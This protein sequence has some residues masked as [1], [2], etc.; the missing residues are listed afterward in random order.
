MRKEDITRY[1]KMSLHWI[2]TV[3]L[4]TFAWTG[5]LPQETNRVVFS[6]GKFQNLTVPHNTTVEALVSRVPPDVTHITVQFHTRNRNATL[7]YSQVPSP[8]SAHTAV[9]AGLLSSL[10][11]LQ[12]SVTWFLLSPDGDPISGIGVILPYTTRDPVPGGCSWNHDLMIDPNVHLQY[13]LFETSIHF[14]PGNIGYARGATPPL[15]DAAEGRLEY[16]IHRYFLPAGDLSEETLLYHIQRAASLQNAQD[17]GNGVVTLSVANGTLVMLSVANGMSAVLSVANETW[18][19]FRS[20]PGRGVIYSVVVRDVMLNTTASYVPAHTYACSFTPLLDGCLTLGKISTKLFFTLCGAGGLFV[21]FF[22]HRFFKCELFWMGYVFAAFI[23][24]IIIT[25]TSILAYD[26]RLALTALMGVVGG[27]LLVLCWWRFG[28]VM[29]CVVVVGLILGF[30]LAAIVFYTPLG[31]LPVFHSSVVFWVTFSCITLAV[32][33]FFVRWPRE[34]N[35]ASCGVVGAYA[36]VLAVN[37]YEYTSLSYITLDILK[38]FLNSNFS[39]KFI[40]VPLQNIDFGMMTV[41]VVL[42]VSGIVLQLHR[43]RSRP[44]FPPSPYI[45]WSQA[46]E[47]RKTNVLDPS[48]HVPPLP[49]RL[50]A[51]LRALYQRSEPADEQTPL[52]L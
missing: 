4:L 18:V 5:V 33:L 38:R 50:C 30:L 34:G 42:G 32:P 25:K 9:D 49:G 36:V 14:A 7:S 41:W 35:I 2:L 40:A 52:L 1:W 20:T 6:L 17:H 3:I 13:N 39:R 48:H 23:V 8:G 12:T 44:F 22:G 11:P 45:M 15:C 16:D 29:A 51:R 37:A 47:R 43:E 21:C 19:S 26:F 28:S 24:F 27:V 31:D 10:L 46:R